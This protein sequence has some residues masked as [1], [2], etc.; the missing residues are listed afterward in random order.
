MEHDLEFRNLERNDKCVSAD[1]Y[2]NG[3]FIV[4]FTGSIEHILNGI[5]TRITL[6]EFFKIAAKEYLSTQCSYNLTQYNVNSIR[7]H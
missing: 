7:V 5:D 1:M 4:K 3:K 6:Y 2:L